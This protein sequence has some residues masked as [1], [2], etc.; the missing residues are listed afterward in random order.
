MCDKDCQKIHIE[1]QEHLLKQMKIMGDEIKVWRMS[2]TQ[3]SRYSLEDFMRS[4][5][6]CG[7]QQSIERGPLGFPGKIKTFL[8][9]MFDKS[10][11]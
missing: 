8:K 7:W 1:Y 3:S 6:A 11:K 5:D 4:T 2:S 9:R 10:K